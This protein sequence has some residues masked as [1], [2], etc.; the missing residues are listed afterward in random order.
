MPRA[1]L[2]DDLLPPL[3]PLGAGGGGGAGEAVVFCH[4]FLASRA[5][6]RDVAADDALA[7]AE[8]V[9]APLPGHFPWTPTPSQTARLMEGDRLLDAY[10]AAIARRFPGRRL[11]L[12]GHSTGALLALEIARRRPDLVRSVFV[13]AALGDGALEGRY[14][15]MARLAS[16]PLLGQVASRLL[17]ARWL[18]DERR[19]LRGLDSAL[20]RAEAG[21][22]RDWPHARAMLEDLRRSEPLAMRRFGLWL[23]KRSLFLHLKEVRASVFVMVCAADPVV[24]PDHQLRLIRRLPNARAIVTDSGHVPMLAKRAMFRR[25]LASWLAQPAAA[26]AAPMPAAA[27]AAAP[28]GHAPAAQP[29]AQG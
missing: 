19:F 13:A 5:L 22:A 12:V 3:S 20:S 25:A 8:A 16:A 28:R 1:E 15:L 21:A 9:C 7:G 11:R 18:V 27:P 26:P 24:P 2:T 4:G 17:L 14:S 29:L 10:C 6:W 23:L